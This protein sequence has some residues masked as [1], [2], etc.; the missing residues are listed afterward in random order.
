MVLGEKE[1]K[2][3]SPSRAPSGVFK[4]HL[5]NI[6]DQTLVLGPRDAELNARAPPSGWK[7]TRVH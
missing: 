6:Y 7:G 4:K 1:K 3:T 2:K 5:L